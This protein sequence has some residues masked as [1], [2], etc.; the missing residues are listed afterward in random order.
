[1]LMTLGL[2]KNAPGLHSWHVCNKGDEIATT[3]K[4]SKTSIL[5]NVHLG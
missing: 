5:Y 1:M 4:T 3:A 2:M